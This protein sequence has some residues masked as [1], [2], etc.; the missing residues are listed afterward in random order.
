[1]KAWC[2]GSPSAPRLG[3]SAA[4]TENEG[5][6]GCRRT[7]D[8]AQTGCG[9][10]KTGFPSGTREPAQCES[11]KEKVILLILSNIFSFHRSRVPAFRAT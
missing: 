3:G 10:S 5:R 6:T 1:M 7:L 11:E 4:L 8:A 2:Q 9:A